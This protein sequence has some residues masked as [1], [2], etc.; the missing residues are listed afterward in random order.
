MGVVVVDLMG[1]GCEK[2]LGLHLAVLDLHAQTLAST[3]PQ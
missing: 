3:R 2:Q 1:V